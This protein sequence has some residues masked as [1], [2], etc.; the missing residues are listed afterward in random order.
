LI[1]IVD[2]SAF[3]AV[4]LAEPEAE[5]FF[6]IMNAAEPALISAGNIVEIYRVVQARAPKRLSEVDLLM[7]ELALE[8]APV[9]AAQTK[10]AREGMERFGKGRGAPPAVLN[11]GDLFAYA[12]ARAMRAPLLFKGNDFG[13][14]D[15][16]PAWTP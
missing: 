9:D 13:A 11:F 2:S 6:E 14:T 1:V 4:L 3:L 16:E 12:L 15:I 10:L 8:T 5:A 7:A